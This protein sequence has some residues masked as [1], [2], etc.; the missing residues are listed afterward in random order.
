MPSAARY[1]YSAAGGVALPSLLRLHLPS[2]LLCTRVP[3]SQC[4]WQPNMQP[5]NPKISLTTENVRETLD[6]EGIAKSAIYSVGNVFLFT[7]HVACE[8]L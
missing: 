4:N 1:I 8:V 7:K 2:V 6:W 3:N 5:T